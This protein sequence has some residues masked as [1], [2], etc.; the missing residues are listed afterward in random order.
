LKVGRYLPT[1]AIFLLT[2]PVGTGI[3]PL[4]VFN[5][6]NPEVREYIM[7]IAEFWIKFGI[8]GWRLDV[9]FEIKSPGFW[10]EFRERVKAVN[11]EAYIVGR[12]LGRCER[13]ARRYS[14]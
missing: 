9:P 5:H 14:I 12:S 3:E 4:P 6:D 7:E 13:M 2:M 1:T 11:P 8:D 10:Q